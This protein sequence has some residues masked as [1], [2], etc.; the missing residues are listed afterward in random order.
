MPESVDLLLTLVTH[1]TMQIGL[2]FAV[3]PLFS[4]LSMPLVSIHLTRIITQTS[5]G[6]TNNCVASCLNDRAQPSPK[7]DLVLPESGAT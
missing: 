4:M 5:F 1:S 6:T 2:V 3:R 7:I